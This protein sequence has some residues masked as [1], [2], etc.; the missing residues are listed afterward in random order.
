[1]KW[2]YELQ[3]QNHHILLLQDNFAGHICPEGLTNIKVKNFGPNLTAYVQPMD[4]GIICCLKAHYHTRYIQ[5]AID[6]YD[7]NFSP[8]QIYD[9]NQLKAIRIAE[10]AW[11]D[12]DITSISYC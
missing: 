2:S 10:L 12:V 6:H 1:M 5:Q 9:I 7:L 11:H 3:L 4:T 8:I